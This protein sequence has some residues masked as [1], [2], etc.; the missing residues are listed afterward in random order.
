M[1]WLS[2]PVNLWEQVH[3]NEHRIP[4]GFTS[5]TKSDCSSSVNVNGDGV[6][7]RTTEL[8]NHE[9]LFVRVH[10]V[11]RSLAGQDLRWTD[12]WMVSTTTINN[13]S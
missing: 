5:Q 12:G 13:V 3:G 9:L 7:Q 8:A 2:V 6:R 1:Q 4:R 11:A 10:S